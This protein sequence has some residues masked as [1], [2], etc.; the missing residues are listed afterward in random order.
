MTE[1]CVSCFREFLTEEK[2][3]HVWCDTCGIIPRLVS[4]GSISHWLRSTGNCFNVR[5]DMILV[6]GK[7]SPMKF[8]ACLYTNSAENTRIYAVGELPE[9]YRKRP[10]VFR[11]SGTMSGMWYLAGWALNETANCENFRQAHPFGANFILAKWDDSDGE[12]LCGLRGGKREVR[13]IKFE[14]L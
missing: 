1:Y 14:E 3:P 6:V 12:D 11:M 2:E 8:R 7:R 5:E 4:Y 10:V 13:E 9:R